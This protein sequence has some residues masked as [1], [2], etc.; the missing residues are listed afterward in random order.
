MIRLISLLCIFLLVVTISGKNSNKV[1]ENV[2]C[3]PLGVSSHHVLVS[4]RLPPLRVALSVVRSV[5]QCRLAFVR[6]SQFSAVHFLLAIIFNTPTLLHS[7]SLY[8]A[9][10]KQLRRRSNL[11]DQ[12][13]KH[14][15]QHVLLRQAG[16]ARR[17]HRLSSVR[18]PR[19]AHQGAVS[20]DWNQ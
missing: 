6:I 18:R 17:R 13:P 12:S 15:Q 1:S 8:L 20:R 3:E 9:V 16:E 2:I 11:H 10:L 7:S 19:S 4:R 5:G 14:L